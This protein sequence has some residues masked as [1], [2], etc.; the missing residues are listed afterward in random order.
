[1]IFTGYGSTSN[2]RAALGVPVD[3]FALKPLDVDEL[4]RVLNRLVMANFAGDRWRP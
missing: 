1:V 2:A 3:Y 4:K